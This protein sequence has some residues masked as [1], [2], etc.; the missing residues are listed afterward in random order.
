MADNVTLNVGSGG[1]VIAAEDISD[2]LYQQVKLVSSVADSTGGVCD[3]M[4]NSLITIS[5]EHHE[6]HE[7]DSF[8]VSIVDTTMA[9]AETLVLAFK[10][11]AGTKRAHLIYEYSTLTGAHCELIEGPTWDQGSGAAVT[12]TNRLRAASPASSILLENRGQVTF[13]ASDEMISN[14]TTLSGGTVIDTNYS[15][16]SNKLPE[17]SRRGQHE[18]ILKPDSTYAIRFT[19]DASSNKGQIIVDW[20]EHTDSN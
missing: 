1:K 5:Y 18:F 3:E 11:P 9:S 4:T 2:V 8:V 10:T 13:T 14:P 17:S 16:G 12:I 7:G 6:I 15:F 19:S 20:Y